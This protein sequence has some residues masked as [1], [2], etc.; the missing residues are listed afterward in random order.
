MII[1][2]YDALVEAACKYV[3]NGGVSQNYEPLY[4][5]VQP[6][7]P[8]PSIADRMDALASEIGSRVMEGGVNRDRYKRLRALAEEVREIDK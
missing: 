2:Q 6:F 8:P 3:E 5:A 1:K 7:L 4:R